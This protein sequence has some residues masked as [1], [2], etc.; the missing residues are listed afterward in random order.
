MLTILDHLVEQLKLKCRFHCVIQ[1]C[2]KVDEEDVIQQYTG[3]MSA[4]NEVKQ[5][6]HMLHNPFSS[7]TSQPKLPD[8]KVSKSLGFTTQSVEEVTGTGLVE[9][10]IYPGINSMVL[11]KDND[12]ASHLGNRGWFIP[13]FTGSNV[14]DWNAADLVGATTAAFN[15]RSADNYAMWRMV[16]AGVQMKLLN[17]VDQDDGWWE[18]CRV[19]A[20]L[21]NNEWMLA[22]VNDQTDVLNNGTLA[23]VNQLYTGINLANIVNEPSYSTGL[24]RDLHRVQFELHTQKDFHDFIHMRD[25]I[26]IPTEALN[27]VTNIDYVATFNSGF[28]DPMELVNQFTDQNMDMIYIRLHCNTVNGSRFHMN[29]VMNQ[30][31]VFDPS[32][33][34]SRF[35]TRC[36]S[37]GQGAASIHLNARRADG[38]AAHMVTE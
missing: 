15:V 11:F 8:G 17:P 24:L 16:S 7:A 33:R 2:L 26:N 38:N 23:P 28:D 22:T 9:M 32:E 19:T 1:C 35:M 5:Q 25:N 6:L 18:A 29:Q 14:V 13:S 21:D 27:S 4:A 20:E 12:P 3:K 34:E 30:E 37:I 10:L 36:H 31:I